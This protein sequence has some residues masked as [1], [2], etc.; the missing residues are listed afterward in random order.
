MKAGTF[1]R[2]IRP[3]FYILYI[4]SFMML[5]RCI[6]RTIEGFE[7]A[8]CTPHKGYCGVVS[9]HE[10]FLWVFEIANIT[11]FVILLAIFHPGRY[12]PRSTK[13]YL[14]PI[15]AC[16]ERVGPGFSKAD[17]RPLLLTIVDPWNL[18][19]I[20]TGKG[21]ALQKFWEEEQPVYT[22]GDVKNT[23]VELKTSADAAAV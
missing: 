6:I 2:R 8:A 4:T 3:V 23:Y 10:V 16:T 14:D 9:T 12:L 18:K 20:F 22:G 1:P 19:G 11:L 21:M 7:E 5:I 15:D 13:I 17:K